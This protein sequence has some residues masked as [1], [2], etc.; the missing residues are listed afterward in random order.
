MSSKVTGK[1]LQVRVLRKEIT[2]TKNTGKTLQVR[3]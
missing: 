1:T 3:V 2:G